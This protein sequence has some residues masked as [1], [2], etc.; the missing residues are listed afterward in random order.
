MT[1]LITRRGVLAGGVLMALATRSAF[2]DAATPPQPATSTP[3]PLDA[4]SRNALDRDIPP[5]PDFDEY[6]W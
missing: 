6:T 4:V 1:H 5:L 3:T 2:E